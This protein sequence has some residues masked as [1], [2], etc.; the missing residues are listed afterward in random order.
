[1]FEQGMGHIEENEIRGNANVGIVVTS[2][3]DPRVVRNIISQNQYEGVWVCNGGRG[4]FDNNDVRGNLRGPK[5]LATADAA[6]VKWLA[7][8]ES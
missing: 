7:N 4:V 1:M 8:R 2:G 3:G 5:D 6:S